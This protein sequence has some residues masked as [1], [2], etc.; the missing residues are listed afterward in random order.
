MNLILALGRHAGLRLAEVGYL[1]ILFAG[2][3]LAVAQ[4]PKFKFDTAR[5][6]VAG[7]A[8]ALG[9]LLLVIATHSGHFGQ[10]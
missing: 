9:G 10:P 7:V 4:V 8:L 3:W 2:I 6:L 1:F 5:T